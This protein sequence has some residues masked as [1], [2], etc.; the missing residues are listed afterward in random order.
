MSALVWWLIP[1]GATI[2]A[3]LWAMHRA[4]PERP[5]EADDAMIGLRRFQQAMSRPMPGDS[6]YTPDRRR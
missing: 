5:A 2:L 1:I 3:V 6:E 4:R